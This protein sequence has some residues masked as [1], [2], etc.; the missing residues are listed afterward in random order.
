VSQRFWR[1]LLLISVPVGCILLA[2]AA[3]WMAVETWDFGR[4]GVARTA[5]VVALDHVSGG[6]KIGTSYHYRLRVDGAGITAKLRHHFDVGETIP[7]LSIPRRPDR[8]IVGRSDSSLFEIYREV[9]G[10]NALAFTFPPLLVFMILYGPRA[11]R[12]VWRSH[13]EW[14]RGYD[15]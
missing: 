8:I 12:A 3:V 15:V 7:I 6:G 10:G 14:V 4:H 9:A 13:V 11:I 2:W 1:Y 5:E